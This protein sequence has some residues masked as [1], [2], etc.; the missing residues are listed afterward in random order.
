VRRYCTL[1]YVQWLYEQL[2][3]LDRVS[4]HVLDHARNHGIRA[5]APKSEQGLSF[6]TFVYQTMRWSRPADA[7][8]AVAMWGLQMHLWEYT[9]AGR[10][11]GAAA[12]RSPTSGTTHGEVVPGTVDISVPVAGPSGDDQQLKRHLRCALGADLD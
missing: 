6:Q 12:A 4:N 7:S 3:A 9:R 2:Q 1:P 10:S 11:A 8:R 5:G